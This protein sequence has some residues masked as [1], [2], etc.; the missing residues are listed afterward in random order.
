MF[1][2]IGNDYFVLLLLDGS[3]DVEEV[4]ETCSGSVS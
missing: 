2:I 3:F 4:A 1:E